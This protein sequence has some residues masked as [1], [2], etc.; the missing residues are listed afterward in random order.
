[1]QMGASRRLGQSGTGADAANLAPCEVLE[2]SVLIG[3]AGQITIGGQVKTT[4][5][6]CLDGEKSDR[7][8]LQAR[9]DLQSH[10]IGWLRK[11]YRSLGD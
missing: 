5:E 2:N 8:A 9:A 7:M 6:A 1:M 4:G 11:E 3:P 10:T